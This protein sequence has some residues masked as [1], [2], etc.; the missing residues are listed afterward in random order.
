MGHA[1][2]RD[3]LDGGY[4]LLERLERGEA[5]E[6]ETVEALFA[7]LGRQ[8]W[9]PPQ[10]RVTRRDR[11]HLASFTVFPLLAMIRWGKKH[12]P[13]ELREA[14]Y[15]VG[16]VFFRELTKSLGREGWRSFS[17]FFRVLIDAHTSR[18]RS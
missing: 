13:P 8:A 2:L 10:F 9:I 1:L 3:L 17:S 7:L 18:G 15:D 5:T 6:D 11:T 12:A 16:P 14:C 4:A